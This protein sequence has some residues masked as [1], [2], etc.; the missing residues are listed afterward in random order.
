[1][2]L[3]WKRRSFLNGIDQGDANSRWI[4]TVNH[5]WLLLSGATKRTE[6]P[7]SLTSLITWGSRAIEGKAY[8]WE[9]G[10]LWAR[11]SRSF[12]KYIGQ[13]E[14]SSEA[15][16]FTSALPKTDLWTTWGCSLFSWSY[17]VPGQHI[18][19]L[20]QSAQHMVDCPQWGQIILCP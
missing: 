12:E 3:A 6:H 14:L 15:K 10:H 19:S 20:V 5:I 4:N 1:M 18:R 7:T 11:A 2:P 9:L 13:W 8:R 17:I 16:R